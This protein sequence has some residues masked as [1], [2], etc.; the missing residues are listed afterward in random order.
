VTPELQAKVIEVHERGLVEYLMTA[1]QLDQISQVPDASR[2]NAMS[3]I[4]FVITPTYGLVLGVSKIGLARFGEPEL[5]EAIDSP[6][7]NHTEDALLATTAAYEGAVLVTEDR[8]LRNRANA[9]G[10]TVWHPREFV[11][12]IETLER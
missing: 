3:A 4:P 11:E 1:I 8:R 12:Y 5:I 7:G 6:G 2:R 9:E 10:G